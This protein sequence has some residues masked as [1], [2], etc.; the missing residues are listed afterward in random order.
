MTTSSL[1]QFG[2]RWTEV[3][4]EK[5]RKYL[6]AYVKIMKNRPWLK[7]AYID[8]F[9]GTGY[10]TQKVTKISDAPLFAEFSEK[11]ASEF[12]DGSAKIALEVRPLFTRY[13]FIEKDEIRFDELKK[14]KLEYPNVQDRISLVNEDSNTYLQNLCSNKSWRNHRAVLF[15]DPFGMQ[16]EWNTIK[17]VASTQAIDL[18]ILFPLGVAVNRLLRKDGEIS[19]AWQKRLTA[20]FGTDDWYEAF[21][22][23]RLTKDLFGEHVTTKKTGDFDTIGRYFVERLKTVFPGVAENPLP[24]YNSRNNP[25]YLLCFAAANPRA[26]KPALRIAQHILKG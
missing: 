24:L 23:T 7:T 21:Y 9:A 18:W 6:A 5:I 1:Q 8:A 15:L 25:L 19:A 22:Q 4:L 2:N 26:T 12:L 3:K 13:I 10:R 14:L 16:V 11:E 17:A 20:M